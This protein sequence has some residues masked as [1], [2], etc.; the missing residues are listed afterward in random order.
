MSISY[1][2]SFLSPYPSGPL[3]RPSMH[4]IAMLELWVG[5]VLF[6]ENLKATDGERQGG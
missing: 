5:Y 6:E 3:G 2:E 4:L 1:D